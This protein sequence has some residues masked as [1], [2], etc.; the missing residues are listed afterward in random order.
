LLFEVTR[1]ALFSALNRRVG[2]VSGRPVRELGAGIRWHEGNDAWP[3]LSMKVT[4]AFVLS[5]LNS[6]AS[7]LSW[8]RF[9]DIPLEDNQLDTPF[10]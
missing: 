8:L 9:L 6:R 1:D 3:L 10:S 5:S 2:L 4:D 7:S